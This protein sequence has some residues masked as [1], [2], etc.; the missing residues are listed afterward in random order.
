[1]RRVAVLAA[2]VAL[3]AA[4]SSDS[5]PAAPT[6]STTGRTTT[7]TAVP[8]ASSVADTGEAAS[9]RGAAPARSSPPSIVASSVPSTTNI[10]RGQRT[11]RKGQLAIGSGAPFGSSS[12]DVVNVDGSGFRILG[13]GWTP[14]WSPDGTTLAILRPDSTETSEEIALVDPA[15]TVGRTVYRWPELG[16]VSDVTW[17]PDGRHL[18][19]TTAQSPGSGVIG[20]A[21]QSQIRTIDT[22]GTHERE[23]VA[24]GENAFPEW[25]PDGSLIAFTVA[26]TSGAGHVAVVRPDGTGLLVISGGN[27]SARAP[28]WS[29]DSQHIAWVTTNPSGASGHLWIARRDGTETHRL[30]D[31]DVDIGEHGPSWSPDSA[32]IA[33]EHHG[34][35][36]VAADG[37][38][39]HDLSP[40]GGCPSNVSCDQSPAWS[41]DG[42]SIAFVAYNDQSA[43][44]LGTMAFD[45]SDRFVLK[46]AAAFAPSW[47]P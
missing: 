25:S 11:L 36:T 8:S 10:A 33:Y 16:G 5:T 45:G 31:A 23:V 30:A 13:R 40:T 47:H 39:Q 38:D 44:T 1:M 17:S 24:V 32:H 34:I 22:D 6:T 28:S 21:E 4:C 9:P 3:A 42:A 19:F 18:A 15:T 35:A 43:S 14:V 12:V 7:S 41:P 37:S 2:V 26:P 20:P 27:E 46:F 29:P